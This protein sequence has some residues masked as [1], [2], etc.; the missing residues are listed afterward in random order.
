MQKRHLAHAPVSIQINAQGRSSAATAGISEFGFYPIDGQQG[1][2]IGGYLLAGKDR[3]PPEIVEAEG[4]DVDGSAKRFPHTLPIEPAVKL[5]AGN[6]PLQADK[7]RSG[8]ELRI[9]LTAAQLRSQGSIGRTEAQ[10]SGK[11]SQGRR[12]ALL[13]P[14]GKAQVLRAQHIH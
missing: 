6:D 14:S 9:D 13:Q 12:H 8:G 1:F 10:G 4:I 7:L 2:G 3:E 5:G 11:Q